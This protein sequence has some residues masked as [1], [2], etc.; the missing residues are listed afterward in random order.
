MGRALVWVD[1]GSLTDI[2]LDQKFAYMRLHPGAIYLNQQAYALKQELV[3]MGLSSKTLRR[4]WFQHISL[5]SI[6]LYPCVIFI[7]K[8]KKYLVVI[9]PPSYHCEKDTHA[10]RW[11]D[12]TLHDPVCLRILGP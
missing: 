8:P 11:I 5:V 1:F 9:R 4:G 12:K 2:R 3:F 7:V 6:T 10:L